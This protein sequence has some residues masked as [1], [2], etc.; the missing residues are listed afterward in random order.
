MRRMTRRSA[1]A[2]S[3]WALAFML[4][5][6]VALG[7][8][9]RTETSEAG[10][11]R[12]IETVYNAAH[13]VVET[14]TLDAAGKLLSKVEYEYRPAFQV[15][16][17]TTTSYGPDGKTVRTESRVEYDQNANFTLQVD[18]LFDASGTQTAGNKL[19]HDPLTGIYCC[20]RWSGSS[21]FKS[22]ACPKAEE[23]SGG[24]ETQEL[25]RAEVIKELA[26]A[27][28]ALRSQEKLRRLEPKPPIQPPITKS[29]REIGVVFPAELEPG[30]QVS[31]SIVEAPGDYDGIPGVQ[32]IRFTLPFES[33]GSAATLAGWTFVTPNGSAERADGSVTFAVPRDTSEVTVRLRQTGEPAHEVSGTVSIGRSARR[34]SAEGGRGFEGSPLCF[35]GGLCP[36][37]G[38][39]SGDSTR[40]LAA[41]GNHPAPIVVETGDV[42]YIGVP[43]SLSPGFTHLLVAEGA[44]AAALPVD[45]AQ[46]ELTPLGR[47]LQPGQT[48]V[49]HAIV[50]GA[51]DLPDDFWRPGAFDASASL[52]Q[53][54]R[55]APGFDPA[56][57]GREGLILAVVKNDSPASVTML[58]AKD[59]TWVFELT[60]Q[61]FERGEFKYNFVLDFA[62]AGGYSLRATAVPFLAPVK[63][64]EFDLRSKAAASA[65][66]SPK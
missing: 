63:G 51:E 48:L 42:A 50:S 28:Q 56:P 38:P 1:L 37:R 66:G 7:H 59:Q 30:E 5:G 64:R 8:G 17:Q 24:E 41:F 55:L 9:Q 25:T 53:A 52:E 47:E 35:K 2:R 34:S 29:G 16:Q 4:A 46:F 15:P 32:V 44:R 31:G 33:K 11:G 61:S 23:E 13:Q 58:G 36:V 22:E 19:T 57:V 27:R 62:K 6:S 14:R 60:R 20:Y 26:E 3:Q 43:E 39:F 49:M 54:R 18:A 40:T 10:G 21:G 45:V 65:A 12:K